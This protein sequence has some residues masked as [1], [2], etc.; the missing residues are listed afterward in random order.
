MKKYFVGLIVIQ[1]V[2][3]GAYYFGR[4]NINIKL[5]MLINS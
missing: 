2:F 4:Y 3:F 1:P 5:I